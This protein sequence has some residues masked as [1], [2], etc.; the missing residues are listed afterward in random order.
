MLEAKACVS[1][2]AASADGRSDVL[3]FLTELWGDLVFPFASFTLGLN[4]RRTAPGLLSFQ[5][6]V[7]D[8]M[9]VTLVCLP[10]M[11]ETRSPGCFV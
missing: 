4:R 1:S 3:M 7:T 8:A 9:P 10:R 5:G 6:R 11:T 2:R